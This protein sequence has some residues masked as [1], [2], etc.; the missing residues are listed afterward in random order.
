M[1]YLLAISEILPSLHHNLNLWKG[2]FYYTYEYILLDLSLRFCFGNNRHTTHNAY[3]NNISEEKWI[4]R[5]HNWMLFAHSV[6][7]PWIQ[8]LLSSKP[9]IVFRVK[10]LYKPIVLWKESDG[11]KLPFFFFFLSAFSWENDLW[12]M[13]G[14]FTAKKS[15]IGYGNLYLTENWLSR[16]KMWCAVDNH[17]HMCHICAK[18]FLDSNVD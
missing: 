14:D 15:K 17:N 5:V 4:L 8:T 1:F 6:L 9:E 18:G 16:N 10:E 12:V 11:V 3:W 7:L 13:V 2:L